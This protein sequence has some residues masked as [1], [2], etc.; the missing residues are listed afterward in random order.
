MGS[1]AD[2]SLQPVILVLPLMLGGW[3]LL[4]STARSL[5]GLTLGEETARSLG[6]HMGRL[7]LRLIV[8]SCFSTP[9]AWWQTGH[10]TSSCVRHTAHV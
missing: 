4:L 10:L 2:R 7:H 5:D 1:L 3:V 8:G 9:G 6:V